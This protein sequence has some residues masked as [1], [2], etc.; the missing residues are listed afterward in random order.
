M[1]ELLRSAIVITIA[2][3]TLLAVNA[4]LHH[5]IYPQR[6]GRKATWR[7]WRPLAA[8]TLATE[9][10][11]SSCV[12][13]RARPAVPTGSPATSAVVEVRIYETISARRSG[14]YTVR[15]IV[16][17][18]WHKEPHEWVLVREA[19]EA[20]WET[21]KLPPGKYKV[22]VRRWIDDRNREQSLESTDHATFTVAAGERT[23]VD[24]VLKHP[25]RPLTAVV[26]TLVIV[27]LG[28][29]VAHNAMSGVH[30]DLGA[31]GI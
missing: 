1:A 31:L 5:V 7:R 14:V 15:T 4:V 13:V 16:S 17:E 23:I 22:R 10:L 20:V 19:R 29:W 18:L 27:G 21:D 9:L 11:C 30:L 12:S 3:V 2:V 6:A 28:A 26:I 25:G 8:L 24:V